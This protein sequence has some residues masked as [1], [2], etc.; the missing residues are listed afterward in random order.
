MQLAFSAGGLVF[1]KDPELKFLL[2][3]AKSL[4]GESI[5]ALPKGTIEKG[6]TVEAAAM[7][8]VGEE[9][10]AKVE[11]GEKLLEV[12]YFFKREGILYKKKVYFFLMK[13]LGGEIKPQLSEI[14]ETGWFS[15][16]EARDRMNYPNE[17][18]ILDKALAI[19]NAQK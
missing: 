10:G 6:E 5:W 13:Y 3:K 9:T 16:D 11:I 7:R 18:G 1:T 14:E 15:P 17:R 12:E 2:I 4:K 19:I 8:E